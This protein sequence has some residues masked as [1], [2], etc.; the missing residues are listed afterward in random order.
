MFFL[1]AEHFLVDTQL[2]VTWLQKLLVLNLDVYE[3]NI[4]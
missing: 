1:D 3:Y 2:L 4:N